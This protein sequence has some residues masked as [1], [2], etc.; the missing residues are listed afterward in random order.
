MSTAGALG[1]VSALRGFCGDGGPRDCSF[2]WMGWS[3]LMTESVTNS[4]SNKYCISVNSG[5]RIHH[6]SVCSV[7]TDT[8][9][10]LHSTWNMSWRNSGANICILCL[11]F[12]KLEK[13]VWGA[14]YP[15]C[16]ESRDVDDHN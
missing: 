4:W 15:E 10:T 14:L 12:R 6:Y 13:R 1:K 5:L 16:Q 7:M 3:L 11:P 8:Q 9:K 2:L